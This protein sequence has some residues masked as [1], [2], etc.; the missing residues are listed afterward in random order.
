MAYVPIDTEAIVPGIPGNATEWARLALNHN[1]TYATHAPIMAMANP[2]IIHPHTSGALDSAHWVM[3]D[4]LDDHKVRLRVRAKVDSGCTG[5]IRL[6]IV[7]PAGP[8]T[9]DIGSFTVTS[10]SMATTVF[11][12][13]A[14][15]SLSSPRYIK[16]ETSVAHGGGGGNLYV[17]SLNCTIYPTAPANVASGGLLDSGFI[18]ADDWDDNNGPVPTERVER[19]INMPTKVAA[20]RPS[21]LV[22]LIDDA[23]GN[24]SRS[25]FYNNSTNKKLMTMF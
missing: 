5:T 7:H 14:I 24:T 15:A 23:N 8:T 21:T 11:T 13:N 19:L 18:R 25:K 1:E 12:S 2:H 16:M 6:Y 4:N 3:F 22:C 17:E 9:T 10:T 20:D